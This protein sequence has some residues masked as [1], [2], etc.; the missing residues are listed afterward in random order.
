MQSYA[1]SMHTELVNSGASAAEI[2]KQD[3]EMSEFMVM[4][5]NPLFNAAM[6]Y[7]E[8]LPMGILFTLITAIALRRK[9]PKAA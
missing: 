2:A 1:E 4:Y 9:E 5:E 3:R 8:I 6:T 7:M